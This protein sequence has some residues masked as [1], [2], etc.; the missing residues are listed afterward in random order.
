MPYL[1]ST[2]QSADE[3]LRVVVPELDGIAN[4]L[5]LKKRSLLAGQFKSTYHCEALLASL[6]LVALDPG[7]SKIVK[8]CV[9]DSVRAQAARLSPGVCA[10]SKACCP[11]C[12][13]I[14]QVLA[15]EN[16]QMTF[17]I[18]GVHNTFSPCDLPPWLPGPFAKRVMTI[19]QERLRYAITTRYNRV[20]EE[21][22]RGTP[23]PAASIAGDPDLTSLEDME[24]DFVMP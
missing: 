10:V 14:Y 21:R 23:S 9:P 19:L 2:L 18:I 3:C 13:V 24:N 11:T 15:Q 8:S 7:L 17:T 16:P 20:M 1:N 6:C 12:T 5:I 22:R 4:D